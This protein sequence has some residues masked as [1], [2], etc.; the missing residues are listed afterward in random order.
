MHFVITQKKG[1]V[2]LV[3]FI[4]STMNHSH[5]TI[6]LVSTLLQLDT[7]AQTCTLPE[8][9]C[10]SHLVVNT[11]DKNPIG[12]NSAEAGGVV[13]QAVFVVFWR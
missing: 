1:T 11:P 8:H 4:C 12:D 3:W 13:V 6:S 2:D 5:L 7:Q 9:V 10:G